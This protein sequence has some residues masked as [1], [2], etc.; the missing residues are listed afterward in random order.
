MIMAIEDYV[1]ALRG[2]HIY[3]CAVRSRRIYSFVGIQIER[4]DLEPDKRLV[5]F[6]PDERVGN[7][8]GVSEYTGFRSPKLVIARKPKEQALMV[9]RDGTVGVLGGGDD[10]MEKSIPM[11][12]D[13]LPISSTVHALAAIDGHVYAA[14]GWR[15]VCYRESAGHW[16]SLRKTLPPPTEASQPNSGFSGIDGF[17]AKDIYCAGG[18]GDVWRF[19]GKQWRQCPVQT[20]ILLSAVCCAGDG[21]VYIAGQNGSILKGREN[22]WKLIHKGELSLPFK[23]IV[24]YQDRLWC[25]SDYG[26]WQVVNDKLMDADLPPEVRVCAGNL[27]VGDGVLLLAGMYGAA[28]FDGKKWEILVDPIGASKS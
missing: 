5:T 17:N 24:W 25:T 1:V 12:N 21:N 20:N 23:D 28:V 14:G 16:I 11:G 6:F 4:G 19:D 27:S 8:V 22:K 13:D 2:F 18:Y 26:I 10:G 15:S 3:D 9:A 7:K